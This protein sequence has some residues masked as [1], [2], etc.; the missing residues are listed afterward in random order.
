MRENGVGE[1]SSIGGTR[2][3]ASYDRLAPCRGQL[4]AEPRDF[5]MAINLFAHALRG[6]TGAD[7]RNGSVAAASAESRRW[8]FRD[9]VVRRVD[10]ATWGLAP[11]P[12]AGRRSGDRRKSGPETLWP[13]T[14]P[15]CHE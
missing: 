12:P 10:L 4:G 11:P 8:G 13:D 14:Q 7:Q 3:P 5:V 9:L 6:S 2:R 15:W 1:L